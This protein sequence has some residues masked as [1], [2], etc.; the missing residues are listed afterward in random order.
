VFNLA[1][2][3]KE[4]VDAH[5]THLQRKGWLTFKGPEAIELMRKVLLAPSKP[6]LI[7][8]C[9]RQLGFGAHDYEYFIPASIFVN[10]A[11]KLVRIDGNIGPR[12]ASQTLFWHPERSADP[13]GTYLSSISTLRQYFPHE[14]IAAIRVPPL[15][16]EP[17]RRKK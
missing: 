16:F 5:L 3:L 11:E 12:G 15:E 1:D 13:S 6:I 2:Q 17:V 10:P 4:Q 9:H 14:E 7:A 8:H